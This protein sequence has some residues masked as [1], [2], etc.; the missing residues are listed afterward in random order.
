MK[1]HSLV[2]VGVIG[3]YRDRPPVPEGS[4]TLWKPGFQ[5]QQL[6]TSA[7]GMPRESS[8]GRQAAVCAV[9]RPARL[10]SREP[11]SSP[12]FSSLGAHPRPLDGLP[13]SSM[14][15]GQCA[16]ACF[17][18]IHLSFSLSSC[19]NSMWAP[20]VSLRSQTGLPS[21][22][23]FCFR[24][25]LLFG[26]REM[27]GWRLGAHLREYVC[28]MAA[29]N[30]GT[31]ARRAVLTAACSAGRRQHCPDARLAAKPAA[32]QAVKFVPSGTRHEKRCCWK[33]VR[34]CCSFLLSRI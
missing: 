14:S 1:S 12:H 29:Q 18:R 6:E 15:T 27:Q 21:F 22:A 3:A 19:G 2:D 4:W 33:L 8:R 31:F 16:S 5:T 30:L 23:H 7:F 26:L 17:C 9:C 13:G 11:F 20:R 10:N 24:G 34:G 28:F 32:L 25:L